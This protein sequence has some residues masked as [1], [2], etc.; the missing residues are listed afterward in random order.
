MRDIFI[1]LK[2]FDLLSKGVNNRNTQNG[3]LVTELIF[4]ILG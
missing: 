2:E 4:R 3:Q 1:L